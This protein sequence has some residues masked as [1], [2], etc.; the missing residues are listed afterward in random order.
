MDSQ[1]W[2]AVTVVAFIYGFVVIAVLF[3]IVARLDR[4]AEALEK[5]KDAGGLPKSG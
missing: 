2:S 5:R 3:A 4:I 1:T